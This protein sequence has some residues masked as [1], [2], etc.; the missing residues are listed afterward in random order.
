MSTAP[1]SLGRRRRPYREAESGRTHLGHK[2]EHTVDLE[3]GFVLSA[4]SAWHSRK[5]DRADCDA[6]ITEVAADKGY[7]NAGPV[8]TN[9]V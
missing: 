1:G 7:S 4:D 3:S 9:W 8:A 5:L 6:V 2:A